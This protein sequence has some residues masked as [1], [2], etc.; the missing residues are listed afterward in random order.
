MRR[1]PAHL[2]CQLEDARSGQRREI[3]H[4]CQ[5]LISIKPPQELSHYIGFGGAWPANQQCG[6]HRS[7]FGQIT[8]AAYAEKVEAA[9]L[10]K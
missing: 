1:S 2:Y 9:N 5:V 8:W 7:F 3:Y 6:L 4:F 10:A